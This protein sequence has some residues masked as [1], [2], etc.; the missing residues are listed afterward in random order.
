[1]APPLLQYCPPQAGSYE[2]RCWVQDLGDDS[3]QPSPELWAALALMVHSGKVAAVGQFRVNRRLFLIVQMR[4]CEQ[5][6]SVHR[7]L[8]VVYRQ[9]MPKWN[10]RSLEALDAFH[11]ELFGWQPTASVEHVAADDAEELHG[12]EEAVRTVWVQVGGGGCSRPR[13]LGLDEAVAEQHPEAAAAPSEAARPESWVWR[14][15]QLLALQVAHKSHMSHSR[16]LAWVL[17]CADNA[18]AS[19]VPD[20]SSIPVFFRFFHKLFREDYHGLEGARN[21]QRVGLLLFAHFAKLQGAA[22]CDVALKEL[23]ADVRSAV[24]AVTRGTQVTR[25]L[26]CAEA[27]AA[28]HCVQTCERDE[29]HVCRRHPGRGTKRPADPAVVVAVGEAKK[30]I[31]EDA[32]ARSEASCPVFGRT[33]NQE[34]RERVSRV[35]QVDDAHGTHK[36]VNEAFVS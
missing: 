36:D 23:P 27:V 8:Q 19:V 13:M 9:H 4:L 21:C 15:G 24:E 12:V 14:G 18:G 29:E 25:C 26:T 17:R 32:T 30:L 6:H 33:P 31:P 5:K 35:A 11:V 1:M 7:K 20:V 3:P 28:D 34:G 10:A 16:R 22:A 2:A